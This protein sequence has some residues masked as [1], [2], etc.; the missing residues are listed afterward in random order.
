M[1][2]A[3]VTRS[4]GLTFVSFRPEQLG[5]VVS[6]R[7]AGTVVPMTGREAMATDSDII[8]AVDGPMFEVCDGL[9]YSRSNCADLDY[10]HID[11]RAGID[12][13]SDPDKASRGITLSV[14]SDGSSVA[15]MG[16]SIPPNTLVSVQ[17]YP[18]LVFDGYAQSV[19]GSGSNNSVLWRAA[20]AQMRDGNLAFVV[21]RATLSGF[22]RA[23]ASNGVLSAGYTDGGGSALL[24]AD[25]NAYG[26]NENRRV[27][28]WIVVRKLSAVSSRS[29]LPI[30]AGA[31][32]LAAVAAFAYK[33][34]RNKIADAFRGMRKR[35]GV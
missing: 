17:L 30:I 35:I 12:Y 33:P 25:G 31:G 27:A 32:I 13:V 28:S 9:P 26:S 23:L 10:V 22:A 5:I 14:L 15:T 16:S 7:D 34:S 24:L 6:P 1:A 11:R 8:A 21:G 2:D 20:I 19:S 18:A 4:D 3:T 29:V